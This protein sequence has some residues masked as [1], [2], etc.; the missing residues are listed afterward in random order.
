VDSGQPLGLVGRTGRVT[1]PH[2]HFEV[3]EGGEPS[4]P[5][6]WLEASAADGGAGD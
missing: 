6:A 4:D 1:G 3:W 2:L 5:L